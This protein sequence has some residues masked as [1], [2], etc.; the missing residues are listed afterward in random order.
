MGCTVVI[1]RLGCC[2]NLQ[3][4]DAM[5]VHHTHDDVERLSIIDHIS[6]LLVPEAFD[7]QI[8]VSLTISMVRPYTGSSAVS[9]GVW[10]VQSTQMHCKVIDLLV[11][12]CYTHAGAAARL[13]RLRPVH[14]RVPPVQTGV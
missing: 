6:A 13:A 9:L 12:I 7:C 11:Q 4:W 8:Q 5:I 2:G 1:Q 14:V 10:R 3:A